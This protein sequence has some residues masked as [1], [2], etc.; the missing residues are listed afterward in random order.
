MKSTVIIVNVG[1]GVTINE[2]ELYY[3][4]KHKKIRGAAID[5]WYNY[6]K[7]RAPEEQKPFPCYPSRFPFQELTNVIMTAHRAW[8]S[9]VLA[10]DFKPFLNNINRYIRG[11]TP[12]NMVNLNEE[13]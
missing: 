2:E 8:Q 10:R 3:A 12:Q 1:R 4:L 7:S 11:E 6:P 13:Y 9:D 5:V